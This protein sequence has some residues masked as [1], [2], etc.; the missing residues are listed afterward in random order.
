MTSRMFGVHTALFRATIVLLAML[1][2]AGCGEEEPEVLFQT[3]PVTVSTGDHFA[4]GL[5]SAGEAYCWGRNAEGQLGDGSSINRATPVRVRTGMRFHDISAGW[6]GHAC[7]VSLEGDAY[8]WGANEHGQLGDGTIVNRSVPS[9]VLGGL[10][11]RDIS[12][13]TQM[14]CGI[15]VAGE[16]YCW[17]SPAYSGSLGSESTS[18]STRPVRVDT[19][20]LFTKIDSHWQMTCGLSVES[21]AYCWGFSAPSGIGHELGVQPSRV[22]DGV[23]FKQFV[24]GMSD[25]CGITQSDDL[26]C[27]IASDPVSPLDG[28]VLIGDQYASLATGPEPLCAVTNEHEGMCWNATREYRVNAG[29]SHPVTPATRILVSRDAKRI[30]RSISFTC[31]VVADGKSDDV[32]CWGRNE[33]GQLGNGKFEDSREPVR[34][35]A[36]LR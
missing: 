16:A 20:V 35:A 12:A 30:S 2:V 19:D 5:T 17:G 4:C 22:A 23:T 14:T 21:E 24:S 27:W 31:A 6:W 7:A 15:T 32:L 34:V 26:Y 8:C 28:R 25:F 10:K 9:A 33:F 11:F 29:D 3:P 18:S 1:V 36:P 13:G